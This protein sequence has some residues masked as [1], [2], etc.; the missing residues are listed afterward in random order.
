MNVE[1]NCS[2]PT[3]RSQLTHQF[4]LPRVRWKAP[5][6]SAHP[7][8]RSRDA[9]KR[10]SGAPGECSF[11]RLRRCSCPRVRALGRATRDS[12]H[13]GTRVHDE[14]ERP[15][16]RRFTSSFVQAH[17][18][19][20][21]SRHTHVAHHR[22]HRFATPAALPRRRLPLATIVM[23]ARVLHRSTEATIARNAA[24]TSSDLLK[25]AHVCALHRG[26]IEFDR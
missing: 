1:Y 9:T 4:E 3:T 17:A 19:G 15:M 5:R 24:L 14:T 2:I 21:A 11:A 10:R 13:H 6:M 20:V 16:T 8:R 22:V 7:T 26:A 25:L 23:M 18:N 12:T